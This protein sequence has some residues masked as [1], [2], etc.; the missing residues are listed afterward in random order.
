MAETE[1]V[2]KVARAID[3]IAWDNFDTYCRAKGY[4][5][6]EVEDRKRNSLVVA[7]TLKNARAAIEAMRILC[8]SGLG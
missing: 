6:D 2:E 8:P 7:R 3:P 1:M 5:L 4:S